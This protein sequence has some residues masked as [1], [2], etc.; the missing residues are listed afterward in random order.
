MAGYKKNENIHAY[1]GSLFNNNETE[2]GGAGG[3]AGME[4]SFA[5]REYV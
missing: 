2:L 3:R 4:E 5:I 1:L